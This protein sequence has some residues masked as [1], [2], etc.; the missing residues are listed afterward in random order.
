MLAEVA[1][2]CKG[3]ILFK[4]EFTF[5]IKSLYSLRCSTL[6]G[7]IW[8]MVAVKQRAEA[9][10]SPSVG[11]MARL[12]KLSEMLIKLNQTTSESGDVQVYAISHVG[13]EVRLLENGRSVASWGHD[14][15]DIERH[16]MALVNAVPGT[17]T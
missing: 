16:V 15:P 11:R 13:N 10:E 8:N 7:D 12:L 2:I 14:D 9:F 17:I 5:S 1:R 6:M 4:I 3:P